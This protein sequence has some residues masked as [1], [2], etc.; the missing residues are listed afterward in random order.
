MPMRST[1]GRIWRCSSSPPSTLKW[2]PSANARRLRKGRRCRRRRAEHPVEVDHADHSGMGARHLLHQCVVRLHAG[3]R[4]LR[5]GQS[6][7]LAVTGVDVGHGEQHH[8]GTKRVEDGDGGLQ[9]GRQVP[10]PRRLADVDPVPV[11]QVV[12]DLPAPQPECHHLGP[13]PGD[14][15]R[16]Q[17]TPVVAPRCGRARCARREDPGLRVEV[18]TEGGVVGHADPVLLPRIDREPDAQGQGDGV[19]QDEET[20]RMWTVRPRALQR[21]CAPTR[22]APAGEERPSGRHRN[23]RPGPPPLPPQAVPPTR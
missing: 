5:P 1:A 12:G 23:R 8:S 6:V 14:E 4:V 18:A 16:P 7:G 19:T 17:P 9:I 10:V 11:Q 21:S 22:S 3:R 15:E 2:M 13:L 20:H